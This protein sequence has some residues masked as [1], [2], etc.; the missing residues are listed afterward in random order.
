MVFN[1]WYKANDFSKK[2]TFETSEKGCFIIELTFLTQM[3]FVPKSILKNILYFSN[4]I[5][6]IILAVVKHAQLGLLT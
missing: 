5:R 4:K 1:F 3:F 2:R 6:G